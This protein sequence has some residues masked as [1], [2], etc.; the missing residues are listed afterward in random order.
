[1]PDVRPFDNDPASPHKIS[2]SSQ[3]MQNYRL[4]TP[5]VAKGRIATAFDKDSLQTAVF[6]VGSDEK[7]YRVYAN[8]D[9]D[10]GW[11]VE[12][13]AFPGQAKLMDAGNRM[14]GTTVV[15]VVGGQQTLLSNE[16][17][18]GQSAW[19]GWK[20][21]FPTTVFNDWC[22]GNSVFTPARYRDPAIQVLS[23]TGLKVWY[24]Q[25]PLDGPFQLDLRVGVLCKVQIPNGPQRQVVIVYFTASDS[26][27]AHWQFMDPDSDATDWCPAYINIFGPNYERADAYGAYIMGAL[28]NNP[29]QRPTAADVGIESFGSE[30]Y[31]P[32]RMIAAGDAGYWALAVAENSDGSDVEIGDGWRQGF[33]ELFAIR[34]AKGSAGPAVHLAQTGQD[35]R[36]TFEPHVLSGATR[37]IAIAPRTVAS[38]RIELFAVG[39]DEALHHMRQQDGD[40]SQW[41]DFLRLNQDAAFVQVIAGR[42]LKLYSEAFAVTAERR[43]LHGWQA[44]AQDDWHFDWVEA[45]TSGQLEEISTYSMQVTVYDAG[46]VPAPGKPVK[47]FSDTP[48]VL[49]VNGVTC[50][51]EPG[52]PWDCGSLAEGKLTI[53]MRVDGLGMPLLKVWTTFMPANDRVVLDASAPVRDRLKQIDAGTLNSANV[54]SND[55]KQTPLLDDKARP[56]AESLVNAMHASMKA[57][58][59]LTAPPTPSNHLSRLHRLND[60]RVARYVPE[61]APL[62]MAQAEPLPVWQLDFQSGAPIFTALSAEQAQSIRLAQAALPNISTLAQESGSEWDWGSVF[63]AIEEGLFGVASIVVDG[64]EATLTVVVNGLKHVYRAVLEFLEQVFDIVEEALRAVGVLFDDLFRWLGHIFGWDDILRS[65]EAI[66]HLWDLVRRFLQVAIKQKVAS[67]AEP[68]GLIDGYKSQVGKQFDEFVN[69]ILPPGNQMGSLQPDPSKPPTEHELAL[70]NSS[71]VNVFRDGLMHGTAGTTTPTSWLQIPRR[72]ELMAAVDQLGSALSEV[73]KDFQAGDAFSD[74]LKYLEAI[75]DHPDQ[76]L[77]LAAASLVN[78]VKGIV[79]FALEAAAKVISYLCDAVLKVLDELW[80]LL[81]EPWDVPLLSAMYSRFTNGKTLTTLNLLALIVATPATILYKL[82]EGNATFPE[83]DPSAA[84]FPDEPSLD[85]FKN[86]LTSEW[87]LLQA[88]FSNSTA[89]TLPAVEFSVSALEVARKF[90]A[91]CYALNSLMFVPVDFVLDLTATPNPENY[92]KNDR[93]KPNPT[94]FNRLGLAYSWLG[95]AFSIP[96][97]MGTRGSFGCDDPKEFGNLVW[98]LQGAVGAGL[99]TTAYLWEG[100]IA[101]RAFSDAGVWVTSIWGAVGL[102]L[103][104]AQAVKSGDDD[105]AGSAAGVLSSIPGPFKWMA[106]YPGRTTPV[107]AIMNLALLGMDVLC[108]T[109]AAGIALYEISQA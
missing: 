80:N 92:W 99:D 24:T 85:A 109:S 97:L 62:R 1:M 8:S 93:W 16:K 103:S 74:A 34:A 9:S 44:D 70:H 18:P 48:V 66:E 47:I 71:G 57:A 29:D 12:D 105:R 25:T 13:L 23:I 64:L 21:A 49:E 81:Q 36:G 46:D 102:G 63:D 20:Q 75:P 96:W 7:V 22:L 42:N 31:S 59:Q 4:V 39:E 37:V 98:L 84:P 108:D 100:R 30:Q 60:H 54:T 32:V 89:V 55:G 45:G 91:F 33:D 90:S 43:L 19:Q 68:G 65:Q 27:P 78:L 106:V 6:S 79:L 51:V 72:P 26:D 10:T 76:F 40:P 38:G 17:A 86:T 107:G 77:Q 15:Y 41:S 69:Q 2:V 83:N 73:S 88:G 3:L 82:V 95:P 52:A 35:G 67:I 104:I 11:S 28:G 101:R 5:F 56:A 94:T 14:D 58:D 53:G 87:L 61:S 50:L